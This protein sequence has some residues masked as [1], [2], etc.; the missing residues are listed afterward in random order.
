MVY[1]VQ[2]IQNYETCTNIKPNKRAMWCS[3][4][5]IRGHAITDCWY[6]PK[7]IKKLE[8]KKINRKKNTQLNPKI[9]GYIILI[10]IQRIEVEVNTNTY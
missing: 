3:I 4:C 7:Y 9:T 6:K 8:K 10:D 2:R 5:Y 1:L